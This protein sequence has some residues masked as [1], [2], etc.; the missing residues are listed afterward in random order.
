[1]NSI[2]VIMALSQEIAALECALIKA[3]F[4]K[5]LSHRYQKNSTEISIIKCGVNFRKKEHLEKKITLLKSCKI[6]VVGGI[7]GAVNPALHLNDII[8]PQTITLVKNQNVIIQNSSALL[9]D[10]ILSTP[11]KTLATADHLVNHQEKQMFFSCG[12][13]AVDMESYY[14]MDWLAHN[15]IRTICIR[16]ISDTAAQV[17]PPEQYLIEFLRAPWLFFAKH[18]YHHPI[19]CYRLITLLYASNRA[20][21]HLARILC[22]WFKSLDSK[23]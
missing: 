17:L 13:D 2:A 3:G 7:S 20:M 21:K 22:V 9:S 15:G 14:I 4:V 8:I 16:A 1:M 5:H 10:R 6:V 23:I 18:V 12:V 19:L 11:C